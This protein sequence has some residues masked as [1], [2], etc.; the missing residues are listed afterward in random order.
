M[1]YKPFDTHWDTLTV[2]PFSGLKPLVGLSGWSIAT[3]KPRPLHPLLPSPEAG[4]DTSVTVC[5][6]RECGESGSDTGV[7]MVW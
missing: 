1:K 2:R 6:I 5:G 4:M 7:T 3:E